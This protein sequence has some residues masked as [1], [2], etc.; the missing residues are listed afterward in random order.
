MDQ[1]CYYENRLIHTSQDKISNSKDSKTKESK[2]KAQEPKV[3]N[4]NNS[5]RPN[6]GEDIKISNKARKR[7]K[8][9][10]KW[11]KRKKKDSNP[12]TLI[13]KINTTSNASEKKCVQIDQSQVTY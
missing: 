7:K 4:S 2:L 10:W 3:L 6:L 1:H 5:L 13:F 9:H 8:K 11:E 12:G